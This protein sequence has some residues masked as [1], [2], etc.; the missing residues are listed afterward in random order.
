MQYRIRAYRDNALDEICDCHV[1]RK[2][3]EVTNPKRGKK[4]FRVSVEPTALPKGKRA[5]GWLT[6]Y[7]Q[8]W[9]RS[10][11][12]DSFNRQ[13]FLWFESIDV[14]TTHNHIQ[15]AHQ[16]CRESGINVSD[17]IQEN[18]RCR[19]KR[20]FERDGVKGLSKA[21]YRSDLQFFWKVVETSALNISDLMPPT[22][23]RKHAVAHATQHVF[24][25]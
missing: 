25:L 3:H 11:A 14:Q 10:R 23:K 16:L 1:N 24:R 2:D 20:P 13:S 22:R 9:Q 7:I 4:R 15:R 8:L 18:I 19:A 5:P 6:P 17:L 21:I 12:S